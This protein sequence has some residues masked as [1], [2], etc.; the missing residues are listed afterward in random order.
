MC[1]VSIPKA[2]AV[3]LFDTAIFDSSERSRFS[4][5]FL[6]MPNL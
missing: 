6:P 3:T 2:R 1:D 4:K 5:F